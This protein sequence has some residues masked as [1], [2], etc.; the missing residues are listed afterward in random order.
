MI[1][2]DYAKKILGSA[3][4]DC[5]INLKNATYQLESECLTSTRGFLSKQIKKI[6]AQIVELELAISILE[7]KV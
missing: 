4:S 2:M 5:N 3:L 1:M 7:D 6:K